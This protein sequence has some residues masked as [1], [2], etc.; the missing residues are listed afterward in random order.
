M[1]L[2]I[3][4]NSNVT[5]FEIK[6]NS[7]SLFHK[8]FGKLWLTSQRLLRKQFLELVWTT[9]LSTIWMHLSYF[10][11]RKELALT[12][13]YNSQN[14]HVILRCFNKISKYCVVLVS[15][16]VLLCCSPVHIGRQSLVD[17]YEQT[18]SANIQFKHKCIT[19]AR[20]HF[21]RRYIVIIYRIRVLIDGSLSLLYVA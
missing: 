11:C 4:N 3:L 7:C 18:H 10:L 19:D 16:Y 5:D 6:S 9:E 21:C 2:V 13:H 12:R 14:V 15:S 8:P 1:L 20:Y 17:W